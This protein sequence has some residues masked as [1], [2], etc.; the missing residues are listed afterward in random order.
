MAKGE[1]GMNFINKKFYKVD[2][3]RVQY[4]PVLLAR[5][6]ADFAC[7]TI[8]FGA[9]VIVFNDNLARV[10]L[11]AAQCIVA[12]EIGKIVMTDDEWR[13]GLGRLSAADL[14]VRLVYGDELLQHMFEEIC[15]QAPY[16]K[17]VTRIRRQAVHQLA[18]Q[19]EEQ[20]IELALE[21]EYATYLARYHAGLM[22]AS[23]I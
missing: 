21:E 22:A 13:S 11:A 9:P 17:E 19:C 7:M 5:E 10:T 1:I 20:G 15:R 23:L 8:Q 14:F 6:E 16:Q 2:G 4:D 12:H 3:V 18:R